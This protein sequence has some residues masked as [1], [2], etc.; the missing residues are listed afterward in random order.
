MKSTVSAYFLLTTLSIF[1]AEKQYPPEPSPA[2][3]FKTPI[4]RSYGTETYWRLY[5]VHYDVATLTSLD[6]GQRFD[7]S[8][9]SLEDDEKECNSC[10]YHS[11][12]R[13]TQGGKPDSL[14]RL[15]EYGRTVL[16]ATV[17]AKKDTACN[18]QRIVMVLN[19]L[20]AL[21][22]EPFSQRHNYVDQV[23]NQQNSAGL[24][25]LA[26]AAKLRKIRFLTALLEQ[27]ASV[28]PYTYLQHVDPKFVQDDFTQRPIPITTSALLEACMS[29]CPPSMHEQADHKK[30]TIV[31]KL[32]AAGADVTTRHPNGST[33]LRAAAQNGDVNTVWA[34]MPFITDE[35][36]KKDAAQYAA[37]AEFPGIAH[38]IK[39]YSK[40]HH[41]NDSMLRAARNPHLTPTE[42]ASVMQ[43]QIS[44][45]PN[46][47]RNTDAQ[48]ET[49]LSIIA[50]EGDCPHQVVKKLDAVLAAIKTTGARDILEKPN[51]KGQT[52]LT[53]AAAAGNVEVVQ[54]LLQAGAYAGIS[55]YTSQATPD[56]EEALQP[57]DGT[58]TTFAPPSLCIS[59]LLAA[60][61]S[62]ECSGTLE[63][64][65]ARQ[66]AVVQCLLNSQKVNTNESLPNGATPL[67]AAAQNGYHQVVM[68]LLN[69]PTRANVNAQ[70]KN[71]TSA[72]DEAFSRGYLPIASILLYH[73]AIAS[74]PVLKAVE[75]YRTQKAHPDAITALQSQAQ[76]FCDNAKSFLRTLRS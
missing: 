51:C 16:A 30:E 44:K 73:G 29:V 27:G 69:A 66:A 71:K 65:D 12:E 41:T 26:E 36:D 54:K 33:P 22:E 35:Q 7:F 64:K 40:E 74:S 37:Q 50:Q 56:I 21:Q 8:T 59:P 68:A 3:Y 32:I 23:L 67:I 48:G 34:L 31:I 61:M 13:R 43:S 63:E 4:R 11:L 25:P 28:H 18:A 58:Q 45:D 24:T 76:T 9:L 1:S 62:T 53:E 5:P 57:D 60:C 72:I 10:V 46:A 49:V 75:E 14:T 42:F 6:C 15:D 38:I 55:T 20:K 70:T 47:I 39:N 17:Y 52:P 19:R 2:D